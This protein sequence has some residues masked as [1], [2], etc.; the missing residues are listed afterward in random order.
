MRQNIPGRRIEWGHPLSQSLACAYLIG[1]GAGAPQNLVQ[2]FPVA[3]LAGTNP[4]LWKGGEQGSALLIQSGASATNSYVDCGQPTMAQ[5]LTLGPCSWLLRFKLNSTAASGGFAERNDNNATNI[6]WELGL[7]VGVGDFSLIIEHTSSNLSAGIA[8]PST[9][10]WHTWLVCYDGTTAAANVVHY[11]D[12]VPQAHVANTNGSGTKG[13]D[14]AHNL[15]IGRATF[16]FTGCID[17]YIDTF[18]AWKRMLTAADAALLAQ[19]PRAFLQERPD[20]RIFGVLIAGGTQTL[21]PTGIASAQAFGSD[22]IQA[23]VGPTGITS[24]EAFGSATISRGVVTLSPTGIASAQAFGT[25]AVHATLGTTGIASAAA[26]GSATVTLGKVLGPTGIASAQAFGT[27]Y[28]K[29]NI[30]AAGIAS[31]N[32]FGNGTTAGHILGSSQILL[33]RGIEA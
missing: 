9:G 16:G 19:N 33:P 15:F 21:Q 11:I 14:V 8:I 6:G 26:F 7:N 18:A 4:P 12:G 17:A 1:E 2:P 25:P 30:G 20:P 29:A 10:V 31:A 23:T 5:D 27:A 22:Y 28:V 13:S 32:V 3:V 24:A